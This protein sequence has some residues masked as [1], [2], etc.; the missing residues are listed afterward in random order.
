MYILVFFFFFQAEDGIRD[1]DVTGVQTCALPILAA[2]AGPR[3]RRDGPTR[4]AGAAGRASCR[5][6]PPARRSRRTTGLRAAAPRDP[7]ARRSSA[8]H[9]RLRTLEPVGVELLDGIGSACDQGLGVILQREVGEDVVGERA[10]IAALR[11][12]H[13]DP[14]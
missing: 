13:T 8:I 1:R 11:A 10:W 3:S 9:G 5:A 4:G 14:Q 7:R 12:A 2:R 6:I